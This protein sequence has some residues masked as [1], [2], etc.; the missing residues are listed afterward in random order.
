MKVLAPKK[1]LKGNLP[2]TA[3]RLFQPF[4]LLS[5]PQPVSIVFINKLQPGVKVDDL[6][7]WRPHPVRAAVSGS[8]W[9][10][11]RGRAVDWSGGP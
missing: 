10:S 8:V 9:S 5:H 6:L 3:D 2:P 4:I 11:C 7:P 1:G